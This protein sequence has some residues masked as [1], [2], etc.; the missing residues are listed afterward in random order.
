MTTK[1]TWVEKVSTFIKSKYFNVGIVVV[2]SLA[3]MNLIAYG[4]YHHTEP[5]Y[6]ETTLGWE[7]SD[8]PLQVCAI[9]YA[10]RLVCD[11]SSMVC[12]NSNTNLSCD[13][14][15]T[16]TDAINTTN[17][18]LGFKAL[19][20][21][22][23]SCDITATIAVPTEHGFTEPGGVA[24]INPHSCAVQTA[25]VHGQVRDLV[26]QHELGHCLGLSHDFYEQS[27]MRPVQ[28]ETSMGELPSWISDSD[29]LLL[30]H[31]FGMTAQ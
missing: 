21:A 18:R 13:A 16:V 27:I 14:Y 31:D 23:T 11:P 5:G 4:I 24:L 2:L 12:D 17:E 7:R 29:R 25:N 15:S 9:A 10:D 3:A 1:E 6:M 19:E 28:T 20:I 26:L 22:S 30:R 8:F